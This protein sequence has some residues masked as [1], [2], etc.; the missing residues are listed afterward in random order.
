MPNDI[1][2]AEDLYFYIC[3]ILNMLNSIISAEGL[4]FYIYIDIDIDI[5]IDDLALQTS[6]LLHF[7]PLKFELK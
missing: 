5:D 3:Q 6:Q 2:S 1:T 7:N 4:C